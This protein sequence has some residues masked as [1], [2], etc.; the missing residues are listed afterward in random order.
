MAE[1]PVRVEFSGVDKATPILQEAA[2]ASGPVCA[3]C[4]KPIHYVSRTMQP[5]SRWE[6]VG[7]SRHAAVPEKR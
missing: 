1:G 2:R 7:H 5:D 6:H 4:G 3:E